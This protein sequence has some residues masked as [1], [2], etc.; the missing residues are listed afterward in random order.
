[1]ACNR[2]VVKIG[3]RV[4]CDESG[5][6]NESA[7]GRLVEEVAA[8]C[9]EGKE[10]LLVSSG[11]VAAGQGIDSGRI[12]GDPV[13]RRQVL[14]A[15]GQVRLM[16]IYRQQFAEHGLEVAQVLASKSD[17]QTRGHYLNMRNCIEGILEAG[18][19]P[20]INENDVVSITEL[21]FTDNDELAGLVAGMVD[22]DLLCLLSS[23][24]GVLDETGQSI[25]AWDEAEH[26]ADALVKMPRD[27]M[28]RGG[29]HSKIV[30][31]RRTASLGIEVVIADGRRDGVLADILADKPGGTRFAADRHAP[32]ARR[33][34]ASADGHAS[35]AAHI[36]SG[37]AEALCDPD[38]LAS[39]LP[40]GIERLEGDFERGDVIR[41]IGPDGTALGCGRAQYARAEADEK[42]GQKGHRPLVHYDYLYLGQ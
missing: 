31:A 30:A 29:M 34:L 38:R 10:V 40:V 17:F 35:G 41:I 22:A 5:A 24:D 1:M 28:G 26:R 12:P 25:P 16:Q 7:L 11:A 2:I 13:T 15:A 27:S 21:M 36:N 37:A 19:V 6:L 9:D 14:A 32:P 18:L 33:W 20:V 4:L 39:L 3:S 23:V 8:I 42:L